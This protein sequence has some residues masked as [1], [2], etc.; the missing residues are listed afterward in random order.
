MQV[1]ETTTEGLSRELLI[2]VPAAEIEA[3]IETRL[4]EI[5]TRVARPGFRPGKVPMAILR[6]EYAPS[7]MGEVLERTVSTN[8]EKALADRNLKPAAQPKVEIK[9][10]AE[11]ADLQ[12]SVRVDLMPE[13]GPFDFST[14][15]VERLVVDVTEKDVDEALQRVAN[16]Q[17]T[18]TAIAE[19]RPAENTDAILV[20]FVGRVDG[21]A[22]DGGSAKDFQ[23][24]LSSTGFIPGFIEGLIGVRKGEKR[25]VKVKFPESYGAKDL[26][27][28]DAEFEVDVKEIRARSTMA[29]DDKLAQRLGFETLDA[30]KTAIRERLGQEYAQVARQRVKRNLL[31]ALSDKVKFEVPSGMVNDEFKTIWQ[32][33]KQQQNPGHGEEGHVHDEHCDHDHD[34][35][36]AEQEVKP[37]ATPEEAK[38]QEEY[39][40][41]AERRVRLGLFL[42]EIGRSNNIEVTNEDLSRAIANEA[43]RFP[44]Q[45]R[46]VV[47]FYKTN[48]QAQARL[49]APIFEDKVVDFILEL[50]KVKDRK[51]AVADL[52]AE[53]E[54]DK[55]E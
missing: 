50:A 36:H 16:E 53:L 3:E 39:R 32:A 52:T 14:V 15:E 27:G 23:L 35:G 33:M 1:V 29:V 10:F 24:D 44:G 25:T 43:R 34:H 42:S 7:L 28:K 2:T 21:N 54:K 49:R 30:V 22:F 47:E 5:G 55:D 45:E 46:Q 12:Y 51:I 41:I 26:A 40:T 31:D 9:S 37:P 8:T 20:D 17:K 13:V 19:D 48:Q 38:E 4:K 18:Y 6:K 11:G